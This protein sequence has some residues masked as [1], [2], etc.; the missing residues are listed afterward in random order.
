MLL[1]WVPSVAFSVV[2]SAR[3]VVVKVGELD[4]AILVVYDL[5][6]DVLRLQHLLAASSRNTF[7][8]GAFA[9][10]ARDFVILHAERSGQSPKGP[11]TSQEYARSRPVAHGP[12]QPKRWHSSISAGS[13]PRHATAQ[14][15]P[16]H[17]ARVLA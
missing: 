3:V 1:G 16:R 11:T 6:V 13:Q 12:S 10:R 2:D 17:T 15:C 9:Q 5:V 14:P 8:E 7:G 4:E